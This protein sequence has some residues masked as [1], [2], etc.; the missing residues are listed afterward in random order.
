MTII[1]KLERA[2]GPAM[3]P[4]LGRVGRAAL[5]GLTDDEVKRNGVKVALAVMSAALRA[6]SQGGE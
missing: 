6:R 2:D 5:S 1:D 4:Y 3:K